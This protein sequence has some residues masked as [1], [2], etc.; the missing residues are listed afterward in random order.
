MKKRWVSL[1][2]AIIMAMAAVP[3]FNI[4]AAADI[5]TY[6][7]KTFE[8]LDVTK[9][10]TAIIPSSEA[11]FVSADSQIKVVGSDMALLGKRSLAVSKG[12]MRWW[13]LSLVDSKMYIDLS[14]RADSEFNNEMNVFFTTRQPGNDHVAYAEFNA[15]S[16]KKTE[17]KIILTDCQGKEIF[18]LQENI[19]YSIR[20]E[21]TRGSSQYNI[22]VNDTL[23]AENCNGGASVY[24]VESVQIK[25]ESLAESS[26]G[27]DEMMN[28][29]YVLIDNLQVLA[30]GKTFPQQYSTQKKGAMP[31]IKVESSEKNED[32]RVF[33]NGIEIAMANKPIV[34]KNT[35]YIDV[36]QMARC[37]GMSIHDDK[38]NNSFVLSNENVTVEA[39]FGNKKIKVN[40]TECELANAPE[41]ISKVIMATPNFFS[42]ALNA[43]VWWDDNANMVVIT[44]GTMKKDG[45]LRNVGGKLY[46]DGE[47]Y[48][49][50]SFN[51]YDLFYQ[52]MGDYESNSEY[53]G[54]EFTSKAA[55]AALKQLKE[56][57]FK[58]IR[59]FAFSNVYSDL[60]YND[61]HMEKYLK[62][63]DQMFDLCD[64]YDIKV[65][66]CMGLME[67]FLLKNDKIE[68][69]GWVVS[70]EN[71][72]DLVV[73]EKCESR[74]NV[75][76]YIEK[77]VTRYKNRD[78]VLMWEINNEG[79]L[80]ADIGQAVGKPSYSLL[81]LAE[82]YGDCADKIREFD[83]EHLITSGDSILRSSQFNLLKDV[84][85]G[86]ELT[87]KSDSKDERLKALW[88]LNDKLDVVSTHAYGLGV[89][90]ESCYT[91]S[92]GKVHN[93][94]F[95]LY[96]QESAL[97]D[98]PLY[99][100][101]TNGAFA[102]DDEDFYSDTQAYLNSIIEAGVQLSHWWTFRSDR[103]GFDDGYL[104]RID[105]G[106]LLN[107]IIVANK[108]LKEKYGVNKAADEN[109][110]D[111]WEDPYFQVFDVSKVIDGKDFAVMASL[112]T[113][114][115]RFAT[116]CG[117]ILLVIVVLV[118]ALTR[119]KLKRKRI[120][121]FV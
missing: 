27:E 110:T 1:L 88:L 89:S 107:L 56:L 95:E 92:D 114:L 23:T 70:T 25:V 2:L 55:E 71:V 53:P 118:V 24:S 51:K 15:F 20:C 4:L 68:E 54:E 72:N 90:K 58:S 49:E 19:R 11:S 7:N 45:I 103:Q 84:L 18:K 14:I 42:E 47:P 48:Y 80:G 87:W 64:K 109:T 6:M 78:T 40:G 112:T 73:N 31:N 8:S 41:K 46:M 33:V 115:L 93:C 83:K 61:V 120:E 30:K 26:S 5:Y 39:V 16:V 108:T 96:M 105:S 35:V 63:M 106:E 75:Y 38:A 67:S 117:V 101:E 52:I 59:V 74:Q 57:G 113:K 32:I 65:V 66:F 36:E 3:A 60:M 28:K 94:S 121:D 12:D 44:T 37:I 62:A 9:T 116:L 34:K 97:L 79:N 22:Y 13:S 111:A 76:K 17:G 81:Q 86:S 104:W 91:G 69:D 100:G 85:N 10:F 119:E 43:K 21:F 99:N 50:I 82:F 98:K 29:P 102:F 77:I